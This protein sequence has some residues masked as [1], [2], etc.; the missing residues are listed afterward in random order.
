MIHIDICGVLIKIKDC[1]MFYIIPCILFVV[2]ILL[3]QL[4]PACKFHWFLVFHAFQVYLMLWL[5]LFLKQWCFEMVRI[6]QSLNYWA[7]NCW[8][9]VSQ[10]CFH[11]LTLTY[12]IRYHLDLDLIQMMHR[13]RMYFFKIFVHFP[14]FIRNMIHRLL[15]IDESIVY[16]V[17]TI[18]KL[19]A[20]FDNYEMDVS[21][22]ENITPLK[23]REDDDFINA[24]LDTQVMQTA[25]HFL[26]KKG[27]RIESVNFD[28]VK[29]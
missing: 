24:V 27:S 5:P 7:S 3:S 19:L 12:K 8:E 21:R 25:M 6:I 9:K 28:I 4:Q 1:K 2:F 22:R 10:I 17:P 15:S 16:K 11:T 29:K 26:N 23:L 18:R 14:L 20:L 13:F